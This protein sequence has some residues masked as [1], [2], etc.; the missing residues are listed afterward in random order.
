MSLV[1]ALK[2]A[3]ATP[4]Q[5]A[6]TQYAN[7]YSLRTS[8]YRYTEW[9]ENGSLG[10]ELYDHQTDAAEMVN[11]ANREGQEKVIGELAATLRA[12]IRQARQKPKGLTQIRFDNR[13]R[14][15]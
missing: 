10:A 13:R 11:L 2:D 3:T 9:G 15:R 7:G 1:P 14:V 6:L 8:R 4:R 12:R 5:A